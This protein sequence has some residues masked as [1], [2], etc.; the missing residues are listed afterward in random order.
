MKHSWARYFRYAGLTG[1]KALVPPQSALISLE[2]LFH[3]IFFEL[4]WW[5]MPLYEFA[6]SKNSNVSQRGKKHTVQVS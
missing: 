1:L 4:E 2:V 3:Q 6:S 5:V